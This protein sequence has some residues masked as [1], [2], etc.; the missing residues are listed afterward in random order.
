MD[1]KG[2]VLKFLAAQIDDQN[3]DQ[4]I[5]WIMSAMDLESTETLEERKEKLGELHAMY[6]IEKEHTVDKEWCV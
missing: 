1:T 6:G 2:R 3:K 4:T 5:S